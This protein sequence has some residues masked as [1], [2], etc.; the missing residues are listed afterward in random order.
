MSALW[1]TLLW[2]LSASTW[3]KTHPEPVEIS[4][5][6]TEPTT[7]MGTPL[8]LA[9]AEEQVRNEEP[10]SHWEKILLPGLFP[11]ILQSNKANPHNLFRGMC[12]RLHV[13]MQF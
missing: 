12:V 6:H 7:T 2:L 9:L 10:G 3:S 11:G 13:H 1:E 4:L 5:G 8:L